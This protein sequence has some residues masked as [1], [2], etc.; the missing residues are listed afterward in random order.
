M[1]CWACICTKQHG[2]EEGDKLNIQYGYRHCTFQEYQYFMHPK[3]PFEFASKCQ[4]CRRKTNL[5]YV[6]CDA[7]VG[8]YKMKISI[9]TL[10]LWAWFGCQCSTFRRSYSTTFWHCFF[11]CFALSLSFHSHPFFVVSN[12]YG[13]KNVHCPRG[14]D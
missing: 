9:R 11:Y 3:C 4:M 7:M 12:F 1:W 2:K 6:R 14:D 10:L 8:C 5:W 13:E